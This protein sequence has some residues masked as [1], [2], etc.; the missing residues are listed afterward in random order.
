[1]FDIL[2]ML[3]APETVNLG[4][5]TGEAAGERDIRGASE[6]RETWEGVRDGERDGWR[7]RERQRER[8]K[9]RKRGGERDQR[10][11]H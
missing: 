9:E 5:F 7:E 2:E 10:V 11:T 6:I 3:P 8:E 1:M 4:V